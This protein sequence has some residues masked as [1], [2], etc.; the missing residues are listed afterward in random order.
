MSH[1]KRMMPNSTITAL[2]IVLSLSLSVLNARGILKT[3]EHLS[4]RTFLLW[5]GI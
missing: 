1:E 5:K 2:G 4:L 3:T